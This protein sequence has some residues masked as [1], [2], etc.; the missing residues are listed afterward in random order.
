[1]VKWLEIQFNLHYVF[2]KTYNKVFYKW[3]L[4]KSAKSLADPNITSDYSS[5]LK[6]YKHIQNIPKESARESDHG[7]RRLLK[8]KSKPKL[9]MWRNNS[10][11]KVLIL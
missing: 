10:W 8:L 2:Q 9:D 5:S 3:Y 4:Y 6:W 11:R 1:M 7:I